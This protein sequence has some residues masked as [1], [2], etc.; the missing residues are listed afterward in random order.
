MPIDALKVDQSFVRGLDKQFSNAIMVRT[1]IQLAHSLD[2]EVVAEGVEEERHLAYLRELG[3]DQLQGYL[4]DKPLD[5]DA[6]YSKW[7]RNDVPASN[8]IR[9]LGK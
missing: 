4:F 3:C 5:A 1:I 2:L 6:F 8:V 7:L 9:L